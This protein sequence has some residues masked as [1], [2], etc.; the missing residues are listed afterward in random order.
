MTIAI[1]GFVFLYLLYLLDESNRKSKSKD[2][3]HDIEITK[4]KIHSENI[5]LKTI[6]ELTLDNV[7]ALKSI[8][9]KLNLVRETYNELAFNIIDKN[10][11]DIS[12]FVR[13]RICVREENIDVNIYNN[14]TTNKYGVSETIKSNECNRKF[15]LDE[16]K[17]KEL[18]NFMKEIIN[19]ALS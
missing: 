16:I 1:I 19:E 5:K 17:N 8:Y 9:P 2:I 14:F 3:S 12:K 18:S 7:N 11:N 4:I 13:V 15:N 6:Y 10:E